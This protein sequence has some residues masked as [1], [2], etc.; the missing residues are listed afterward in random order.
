MFRCKEHLKQTRL[1]TKNPINPPTNLL[2]IVYRAFLCLFYL[3]SFW[4]AESLPKQNI[5]NVCYISFLCVSE[6][7][8]AELQLN[9][10]H[11]SAAVR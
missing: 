9:L 8:V 3:F 10:T 4:N 6:T 2:S 1:K 5:L 11:Y 7:F